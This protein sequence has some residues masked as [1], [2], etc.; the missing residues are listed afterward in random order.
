MLNKCGL[1]NTAKF[2]AHGANPGFLIS[3]VLETY[4]GVAKAK[5]V[6]QH[7]DKVMGSTSR[8]VGILLPA[9]NN[10]RKLVAQIIHAAF[11]GN[12]RAGYLDALHSK[13]SA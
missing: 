4:N 7:A 6:V 9:S 13:A 3:L 12:K 2:A 8:V 1:E 11:K 10:D 5:R